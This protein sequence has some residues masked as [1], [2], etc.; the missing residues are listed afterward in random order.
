MHLLL[1][2]ASNHTLTGRLCGQVSDHRS[3]IV[4]FCSIIKYL[5]ILSDMI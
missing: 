2:I 4:P 5:I 3:G 1:D